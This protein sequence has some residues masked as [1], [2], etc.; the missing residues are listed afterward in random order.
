MNFLSTPKSGLSWNEPLIYNFATGGEEPEDVRVE[1]YDIIS[2]ELIA[3][4]MLYGV[5]SAQI[6]IA[7]YLRSQC[8]AKIVLSRSMGLA[9]SPTARCI[10]VGIGGIMSPSALF[11]PSSLNIA[12]PSM[13]TSLP[14]EQSIE[15]GTTITFSLYTPQASKVYV[16]VYTSITSRR[17]QFN[18]TRSSVPLDMVIP[19]AQFSL[20]TSKIVV[21][22][23]NGTE[24]FRTLTYNIAKADL[25][26]KQLLWRNNR[27]GIESYTFPRSIRLGVE[28]TIQSVDTVAGCRSKLQSS[29]QHYRL[30]SALETAAELER[31][32]EI[33]RSPYVYEVRGSQALPLVLDTR[34]VECGSHGELRQLLL[35][36]ST[37]WKGGEL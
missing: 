5:T 7:P 14:D 26:S 8:E 28:A 20:M 30:C 12:E 15:Y 27:G 29:V 6:D 18:W 9:A 13:L 16:T 21:E 4:K 23:Y 17:Q 19:T 37:E 2:G 36:I 32:V 1:I 33:V 3:S 10:G 22:I 35:E 11:L 31:I 24:L 25:R 34:S